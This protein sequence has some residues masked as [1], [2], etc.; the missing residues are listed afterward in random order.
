MYK[1]LSYTT[2]PCISARG[3]FRSSRGYRYW[4]DDTALSFQV[5]QVKPYREQ[6]FLGGRSE[7]YE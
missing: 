6:V 5:M 4:E 2:L 3:C 1:G 7:R